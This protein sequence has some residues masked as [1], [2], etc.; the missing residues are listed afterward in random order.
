MAQYKEIEVKFLNNLP[1]P[2][3]PEFTPANFLIQCSYSGLCFVPLRFFLLE[4]Q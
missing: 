3:F 4:K 2:D 1:Q